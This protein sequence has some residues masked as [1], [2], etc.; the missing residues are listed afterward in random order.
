MCGQG[1]FASI[2]EVCLYPVFSDGR[3]SQCDLKPEYSQFELKK[4]QQAEDPPQQPDLECNCAPT[5]W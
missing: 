3:Q 2:S 1:S 5:A 4:P